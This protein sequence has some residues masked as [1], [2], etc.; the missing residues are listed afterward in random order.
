MWTV[1]SLWC[2]WQAE[3]PLDNLGYGPIDP[4][5]TLSQRCFRLNSWLHLWL[6]SDTQ[7]LLASSFR[8]S[9]QNVQQEEL[10]RLCDVFLKVCHVD[11]LCR[12]VVINVYCVV[13]WDHDQHFALSSKLPMKKPF[14]KQ[15]NWLWFCS[16]PTRGSKVS[17]PKGNT[18][19]NFAKRKN[20]GPA[21]T[22]GPPAP[23]DFSWCS[24]NSTERGGGWR[25]S[26]V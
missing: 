3:G 4:L 17:W 6:P 9:C 10:L 5:G 23:S 7:D 19:D 14:L 13:P 26:P 15:Y 12:R 18:E 1:S 11:H 21:R 20:V 22:F 16:Q 2:T 24:S 8:M 25:G